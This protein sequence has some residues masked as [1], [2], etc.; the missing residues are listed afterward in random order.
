[1]FAVFA[2][3]AVN[4][5]SIYAAAVPVMVYCVFGTGAVTAPGPTA[6]DSVL[7][8]STMGSV[9]TAA[10]VSD[11]S[12]LI[13]LARVLALVVGLLQLAVGLLNFGSLANFL[14]AS[15]MS[16]FTSAAALIILMGQVQVRDLWSL[17]YHSVS[18]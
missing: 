16:S 4:P 18:E 6:L 11:T 13:A 8:L 10:Q 1:M 9:L 12:E 5:V 2:P 15:V 3:P 7:T 14:S 17:C